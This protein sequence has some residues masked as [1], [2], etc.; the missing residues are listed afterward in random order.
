MTIDTLV[1]KMVGEI[2]NSLFLSKETEDSIEHVDMGYK[3]FKTTIENMMYEAYEHGRDEGYR[4]GF[5]D[6]ER[7][8]R[9]NHICDECELE[10]V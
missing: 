7:D 3:E 10:H 5:D 4:E 6:G 1:K 2:D 9:E 8:E